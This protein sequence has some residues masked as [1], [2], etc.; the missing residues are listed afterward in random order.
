MIWMW[1]ARAAPGR[2]DDLRRWAIEALADREGEV[3]LS[4]QPA[5][6]LVVIILRTPTPAPPNRTPAPAGADPGHGSV[7][8]TGPGHGTDSGAGTGT[9]QGTDEP[10]GPPFPT[11]P[12]DLLAGAAHAWPFRQVH[13]AH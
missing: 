1:E 3:Y 10:D 13:P 11:P 7:P 5:G 12:A 6:D 4:H 2:L 8:G 9:G